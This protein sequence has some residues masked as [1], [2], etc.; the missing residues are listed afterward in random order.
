MNDGA[1][2]GSRWLGLDRGSFLSTA[3]VRQADILGLLD[4]AANLQ[5]ELQRAADTAGTD[6]TAARALQRLYD[7]HSEQVGS[8][9]AWTKPLQSARD[10]RVR[11]Q[12]AL[13]ETHRS[14]AIFLERRA[15]VEELDMR[16]R[17]LE[18]EAAVVRAALAE[19]EASKTADRSRRARALSERFPEGAPRR[20]AVD[21]RLAQQTATA[22][23][24]WHSRR[25]P[26]MISGPSV[27]ELEAQFDDIDRQLAGAL[28]SPEYG[29]HNRRS[30]ARA[31]AGAVGMLA[32]ESALMA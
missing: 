18:R 24:A 5:D 6:E 29:R 17:R 4:D 28:H 25:E 22:L 10:E 26:M 30:A 21:D 8:D 15:T 27:P 14:H 20:A 12:R 19:A 32:G 16:V 2:D 9:R 31:V 23:A 3:C 11:A 13:E 7:F 1:P